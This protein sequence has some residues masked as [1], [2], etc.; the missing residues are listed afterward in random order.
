MKEPFQPPLVLFAQALRDHRLGN[1][2]AL[3]LLATAT[4]ELFRG[5][6]E[7]DD[8]ALLIHRDDRIER[9]LQNGGFPRFAFAQCPLGADAFDAEAELT[10]DGDC[11]I[12]LGARERM[13]V[14]IVGHE[15]ADQTARQR[16][17]DEG[18]RVNAL[19]DH[20]PL[21]RFGKC[22]MRHVID[23]DRLRVCDIGIPGRVAVDS[24]PVR[25]GQS[26]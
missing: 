10:R 17:W 26:A 21:E 3:H 8:P 13:G 11:K 4:Q 23:A 2:P 25:L 15:L 5:R 16:Q 19:R 14:V 20:H 18:E 7:V 24:A 6:I 9:R 1:G 12:D 22:S